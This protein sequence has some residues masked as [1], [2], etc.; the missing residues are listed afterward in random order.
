[1]GA[2]WFLSMMAVIALLFG[3]VHSAAMATAMAMPTG[4]AGVPVV[5]AAVEAPCHGA[6]AQAETAPAKPD[7]CPG[8]CDG[9]CTPAAAFFA[10]AAP[11]VSGFVRAVVEPLM[12]AGAP[13]G[14]GLADERPP[15]FSA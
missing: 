10:S 7:C 4:M 9:A 11:V 5:S 15:K 8:D 1:M 3:G 13:L 14:S 6:D 12:M 2:R